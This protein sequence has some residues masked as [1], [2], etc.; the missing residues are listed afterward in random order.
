MDREVIENL[1]DYA[2]KLKEAGIPVKSIIL[3]GSRA[4]G[5][6]LKNSDIDILVILEKTEQNFLERISTLIKYWN[7]PCS[8]EVF[9]YTINEIINLMNRGSIT[10]YDSLEHGIIVIDDGTFKKL[11]EIFNKAI[12]RKII[13]KDKR[14]WWKIPLK[15]I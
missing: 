7:K 15:P 13:S 4:R 5:E 2:R 12:A 14:G 11:K 3:F 6:H 1:R 8:L 9:P 10:L